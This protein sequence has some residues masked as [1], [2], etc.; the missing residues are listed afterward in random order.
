MELTRFQRKNLVAYRQYHDDPPTWGGYFRRTWHL[1]LFIVGWIIGG[2]LLVYWLGFPLV[3]AVLLGM[4]AGC[5]IRDYGM[6]RKFLQLWPALA[7]ILDW[8]RI[9][10][11]LQGN[12]KQEKTG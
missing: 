7:E 3:S 12:P 1:Y 9:D 6:Y 8:E 11:L 5:L 2:A 4:L 10:D